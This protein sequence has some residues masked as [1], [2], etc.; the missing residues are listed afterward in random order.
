MIKTIRNIMLLLVA[1][2]WIECYAQNSMAV[3]SATGHPQEE[4]TL[5]ISI[6]NSV[7]FVAFQT[8]IPLGESLEYVTGSAVLTDRSNGHLLSAKVSGSTLK[9]YAYSLSNTAFTGSEGDVMTFRLRLLNEPG[10]NAIVL[11]KAKIAD[12]TGNALPLETSN[13]TV[14]IFSPKAE[15]TNPTIELGRVPIRNTHIIGLTVKNA[16]NEPLTIN[17]L[18]YT[19]ET[20]S[21][22]TFSE[23]VIEGGATATF[24]IEYR[25]M[26]PGQVS[27][28]ITAVSNAI[29]GNVS[30]RVK[31]APYSVN[32][33][34]VLS[35]SGYCDSIVPINLKINNM[36]NIVGFQL[37]FKMPTALKYIPNSVELTSRKT[38]HIA[39][40]N[41]RNDTLVIMAY[42]PS[43][44]AFSGE[45]GE[46]LS[47]N[48]KIDG[49][50]NYYY[51]YPKQVVLSDNTATNVLSDTYDGYV[52]VWSPSLYC[53]SSI[54][55]GSY[56]V[57]ETIEKEF[58]INNYGNAQLRIDSVK[59]DNAWFTVSDELPMTLSSW[60][61][62]YLHIRYK[63][64]TAGDETAIMQIY[65][66][67][68]N[69]RMRVV[70][71]TANT[72]EP[73][74]LSI[75][76][77]EVSDNLDVVANIELDN[78]SDI[79][80]IQADFTYPSESY[81]VNSSDFQLSARCSNH[82]ISATRKSSNTF[83]ILIFS[84]GNTLI[85]GHE[86]TIVSVN[87]HRN[88]QVS[89]SEYNITMSNIV[90]SNVNGVNMASGDNP[91]MGF[92]IQ[93]K[94]VSNGWNWIST[95]IKTEGAEGLNTLLT[96]IGSNGI[97]LKSQSSYL[98]YSGN[99]WY[100][101]MAS[102]NN[103]EMY[104][105]QM[106][107]AGTLN[108]A[109]ES[110]VTADHPISLTPG[111]SWIGYPS[112][113]NVAINDALSGLTPA[114]TDK[115]VNQ[116]TYAEYYQGV[117]WLG[118]LNTLQGGDGYMYL[119]NSANTVSLTYS[120]GQKDTAATRDT[121]ELH[122]NPNIHQFPFNMTATSLLF[123]NG[124]EVKSL[125][126]E[127][128]AFCGD[129]CR[130][131]A[132]AIYVEPLDKYF[133]FLMF[134]G[135]EN[136]EF[137]LRLYDIANDEEL[138]WTSDNLAVFHANAS[139]GTISEPYIIEFF[140][141]ADITETALNIAIYPNPAGK[142][143][144]IK[145]N[146]SNTTK[147]EMFNSTGTKIYECFINGEGHITTPDTQGVFLIKSTAADGT[148]SCYKLIVE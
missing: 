121:T 130:G 5:N 124:E 70:N 67:D 139:L 91:S 101:N 17:E 125:D 9:I 31:A 34:H 144:D 7:E 44:S 116:S 46:I 64:E 129:E 97:T 53:S 148:T 93:S 19:S 81:T 134:H 109:G 86:G 32:E 128:G 77:G 13:G 72:Y 49:S 135:E 73:N 51:L 145:I 45:D 89:A 33:L 94:A 120:S 1:S 3:T 54:D 104:M 118:T 48:V 136:D 108:M 96:A 127:V 27:H 112:K 74:S 143:Q 71:A 56:P 68:P 131:S 6:E 28:T 87:M 38:D 75:S 142:R 66:N 119:N 123:I 76:M 137:T 80:A 133:F 2:V 88:E 50:S 90:I 102:I 52:N 30:A 138:D 40:A 14:T 132:R 12:A 47:F 82:N 98:S 140:N 85:S 115:L 26:V 92:S 16:G 100:G 36:D 105:V 15:I 103:E 110:L 37:K 43:N 18:Q 25:P 114:N 99:E 63:G 21:C 65:C 147:I 84:M 58:Q 20:L 61:T 79:T 35:T 22:P 107:D 117:G 95:N 69:G 113:E 29:N 122:W 39:F 23:T 83:R 55:M 146:V 8:E 10:E 4:V 106:G 111:W 41:M 126:Y 59:F 141:T 57:T 60:S 24:N 11:D 62:S 78:Y 42:S